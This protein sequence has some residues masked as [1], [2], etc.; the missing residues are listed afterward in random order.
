MDESIQEIKEFQRGATGNDP[1]FTMKG[2]Q[3]EMIGTKASLKFEKKLDQ[4][5]KKDFQAR[6]I[7][8]AYRG[9]KGRMFFKFT[10]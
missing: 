3:F 10:L 4:G 1:N 5:Y 6:V 8:R 7:Q 9:Y 2:I